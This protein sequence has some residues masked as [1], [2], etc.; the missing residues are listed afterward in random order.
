M[1]PLARR[2]TAL[3]PNNED[4]RLTDRAV[5]MSLLV[6]ASDGGSPREVAR[7]ADLGPSA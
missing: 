2:S 1:P 6:A 4:R 5:S 3:P 7:F